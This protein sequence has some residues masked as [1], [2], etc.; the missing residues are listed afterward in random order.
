MRFCVRKAFGSEK[1]RTHREETSSRRQTNN[2]KTEAVIATRRV[3]V[4]TIGGATVERVVVPRNPATV[5]S[6]CGYS[7]S[8]APTSP[9]A[10]PIWKHPPGTSTMSSVTPL[11]KSSLKYL[12]LPG[13]RCVSRPV[14]STV[15]LSKL[16]V[17]CLGGWAGAGA[18]RLAVGL[19]AGLDWG[20]G[21]D[22]LQSPLK[23]RPRRIHLER[24]EADFGQSNQNIRTSLRSPLE[25]AVDF[26]TYAVMT[27][28]GYWLSTTSRT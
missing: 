24:V 21:A 25:S 28:H 8:L 4:V 19:I 27:S 10:A 5:T 9:L 22:R 7:L 2:S 17:D 14:E 11:P 13:W 1:Y 3:E 12:A 16:K 6:C 20:D 26:S 23:N 15:I 18:D